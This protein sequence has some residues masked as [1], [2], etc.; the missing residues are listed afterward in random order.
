MD[1]C[2]L[3][4]LAT[5][6]ILPG[7]EFHDGTAVRHPTPQQCGVMLGEQSI[8]TQKLDGLKVIEE[9][10]EKSQNSQNVRGSD[11]NPINIDKI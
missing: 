8:L 1:E 9:E 11:K 2:T 10:S 7:R 4:C 5:P 6:L 3:R